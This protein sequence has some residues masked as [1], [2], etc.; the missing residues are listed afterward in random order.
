MNCITKYLL[1]AFLIENLCTQTL[2]FYRY[3][4]PLF[5]VFLALGFLSVFMRKNW[6]SASRGRFGWMLT[7]SFI[8]TFHCFV[9]GQEFLDRDNVIYLAAK[10]A[11]FFIIGTSLNRDLKFYEKKGIYLYAIISGLFIVQGLVFPGGDI[12]FDGEERSALGFVNSNALGG[13]ATIVFGILLSEF[14]NKKW[15]KWGL[16]ICCIAVFAVFASGSRSSIIVM[17]LMLISQYKVSFKMVFIIAAI[18]VVFLVFLPNVGIEVA[19]INR[20][21]ATISGELGSNRDSEVEAAKWMIQERP[22]TGWGLITENQGYAAQITMMSSH[23]SY[24]DLAKTMGIPLA[25]VWFLIVISVLIKYLSSMRRYHL[26]F[27]FFCVYACCTLFKGCFEALFAG[28]HE[29][30]TNMFFV[31]LAVLS[32]RLYNV[33]VCR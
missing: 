12:V 9:V 16:L 8:Y 15:K 24:L 17:V 32:M 25:I 23:N 30:Q 29:I 7:L 33:K 6:T 10:V 2:L 5:Y 11:T 27:D 13:I 20:M 18:A 3:T 26:P 21:Q 19:G 31:S 4:I 14:R 1:F 28:A 22:L